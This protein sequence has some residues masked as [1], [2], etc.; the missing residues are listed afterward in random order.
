MEQAI[1]QAVPFMLRS[2][3]QQFFASLSIAERQ[4]LMKHGPVA[5]AAAARGDEVGAAAFVAA[6]EEAGIGLIAR[7]LWPLAVAYAD[8]HRD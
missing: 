3:V 8:Q 2:F 6:C 7:Q 1:L 4:R 5:I